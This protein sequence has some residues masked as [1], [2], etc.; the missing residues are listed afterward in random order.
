M[1]TF[2]PGYDK[3]AS[4]LKDGQ[5]VATTLNITS[6]TWEERVKELITTHSGTVGVEAMIA[7]ILSGEGTIEANLQSDAIFH[8]GTNAV[9]AGMKGAI[10]LAAGL[11]SPFA[12]HCMVTRVNWKSVVDGLVS[13]NFNV[14]LDATSGSYTSAA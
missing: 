11:S 1:A 8:T 14:K 10:G 6:W 9:R 13:Y 2:I 7:G 5:V 12:I 3:A 4:V